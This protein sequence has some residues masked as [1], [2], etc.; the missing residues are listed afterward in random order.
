MNEY[1]REAAK[2]NGIISRSEENKPGKKKSQSIS[3]RLKK[4]KTYEMQQDIMRE[5]AE[6][7]QQDMENTL[8]RLR[9]AAMCDDH[10]EIMHMI[11]QLSGMSTK[12][13]TGLGNAIRIIS[14]P[15]RE[16]NVK[17]DKDIE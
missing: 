1:V 11:D 12:R 4:A 13:F 15:D 8:L 9:R 14:D 5:W 2:K 3:T 6:G 10:G 7:W 16:L 17:T